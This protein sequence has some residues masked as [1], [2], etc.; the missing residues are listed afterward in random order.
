MEGREDGMGRG[1]EASWG[2]DKETRRR[3]FSSSIPSRTP[4]PFSI[5]S[6]SNLQFFSVFLFIQITPEANFI[7]DLGLDS[8]DTVEVTMAIE[9]EFNVELPDEEAESIFTVKQAVEKIAS[10]CVQ[11][12]PGPSDEAVRRG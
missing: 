9:E 10:K 5:P 1:L 3:W 4:T 2:G 11:S 8:L 6:S 7:S 12:E